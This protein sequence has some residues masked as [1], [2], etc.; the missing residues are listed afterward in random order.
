V[1]EAGLTRIM[2]YVTEHLEILEID[3][4][5]L[6]DIDLYQKELER[7][8]NAENAREE[9]ERLKREIAGTDAELKRTRQA[10]RER[11]GEPEAREQVYL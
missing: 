4:E 1:V 7:E 8:Q 2:E 10:R 3:T 9:V 5:T 6:A 11:H